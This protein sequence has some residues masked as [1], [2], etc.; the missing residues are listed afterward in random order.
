MRNATT[1]GAASHRLAAP[2]LPARRARSDRPRPAR[3]PTRECSR[4]HRHQYD[5]D[6]AVIGSRP[7]SRNATRRPNCTA[8]VR[9][10]RGRAN[11][12]VGT[13]G[14]ARGGVARSRVCRARVASASVARRRMVRTHIACRSIRA[15][16]AR[17]GVHRCR[18]RRRLAPRRGARRDAACARGTGRRA[19]RQPRAVA[20]CTPSVD[21][22][23][24][25]GHRHLVW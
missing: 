24:V 12:P 4:D 22:T 25:V 7:A 19:L 9:V 1:K 21:E 6:A 17:V 5:N 15:R 3:P 16:G 13:G 10:P 2:T 23:D 11:T 20:V 8:R 18:R 14:V